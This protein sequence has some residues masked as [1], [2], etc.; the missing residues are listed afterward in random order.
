MDSNHKNKTKNTN[1]VDIS[2]RP[3]SVEKWAQEI[4][5]K[6]IEEEEHEAKKRLEQ[7]KKIK[8]KRSN[9]FEEIK[10]E[11]EI[12]RNNIEKIKQREQYLKK[13]KSKTKLPKIN[14]RDLDY[15]VTLDNTFYEDTT[16]FDQEMADPNSLD[17]GTMLMKMVAYEISVENEIYRNISIKKQNEQLSFSNSVEESK[18]KK[19][20]KKPRKGPRSRW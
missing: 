20:K 17:Y 1:D 8:N 18:D 4:R 6:A 2:K 10:K 12:Q 11:R 19:R 15:E 3:K 9:I 7:I 13:E 5:K 16:V 14:K